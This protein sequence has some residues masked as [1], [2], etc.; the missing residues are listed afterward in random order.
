M[1]KYPGAKCHFCGSK[2]IHLPNV[3]ISLSM[4]GD[5]YSFCRKCLTDMSA[6]A[7]WRTFFKKLKYIYPPR[8][9]DW[10]IKDMREELKLDE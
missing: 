2:H 1:P 4:W 6:E 9:T 8:L 7:F 5:N 10:A 3:G